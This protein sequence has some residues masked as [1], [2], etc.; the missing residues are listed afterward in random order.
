MRLKN[1]VEAL[2]A[3][4]KSFHEAVTASFLLTLRVNRTS[5]NFRD[6]HLLKLVLKVEYKHPA[7]VKGKEVVIGAGLSI[8]A[9]DVVPGKVLL[10]SRQNLNA[11]LQQDIVPRYYF[12]WLALITIIKE[13][14]IHLHCFIT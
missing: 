4:F 14:F 11:Q 2:Q 9:D 7:Q 12:A 3:C 1:A 10:G 8:A 13:V 5:S 6:I